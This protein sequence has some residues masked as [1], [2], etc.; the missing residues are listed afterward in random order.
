MRRDIKAVANR[1]SLQKVD[2]SF[3]V[4]SPQLE[5]PKTTLT[6]NFFNANNQSSTVMN[7]NKKR[8]MN[9]R[10]AESALASPLSYNASSQH[11]KRPE[12]VM[13]SPN[14]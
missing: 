12:T 3:L 1:H 11:T 2:P 9:I 6:S 7:S 14:R 5:R 4:Q 13:S 8:S 10:R